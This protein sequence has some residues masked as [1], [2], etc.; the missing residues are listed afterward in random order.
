MIKIH[1]TDI[2]ASAVVASLMS[3]IKV[4]DE[5]PKKDRD[6]VFD[7]LFAGLG[8][9]LQEIEFEQQE[10]AENLQWGAP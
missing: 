6:R 4:L 8:T 3:T 5:T 9:A 1:F 7:I 2:E 10:S